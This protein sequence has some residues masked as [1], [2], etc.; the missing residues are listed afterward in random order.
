[1]D[2]LEL[3]IAPP[4]NPYPTGSFVKRQKYDPQELGVFDSTQWHTFHVRLVGESVTVSLDGKPLYEL[5]DETSSRRGCISLQ[6]NQG[7]V[8]FRNVM[9][10]PVE[11]ISLKLAAN[12]EEDWV[13]GEKEPGALKVQPSDNGLRIQGGLGKVESKEGFGDFW[14]QA[15]YTLSKP[16][17]NSGIFFRCVEDSMLDGY[18][19]QINHAMVGD[20][21]LA[22]KDAGAG[23]IFRRKPARIVVGDGTKPTYISLLANGPQMVTW[24]NGILTTEF[25]DDR[26]VDPNPR[27]GKRLEAGSIALQ[28]HDP[29]T[30]VIFH[31]LKVST[32]R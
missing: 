16:E 13:K 8:E 30:D 21:P 10:R 3:N 17:V 15:K 27:K 18:E 28:G 11:P 31:S 5:I 25:T 19:C 23:A 2:C 9:L 20:D 29:T 32:L 22:P 4:D 12:W 6:H 7:V 14:L 26:P 1:L 24:V